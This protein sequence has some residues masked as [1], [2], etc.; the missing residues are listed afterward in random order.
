MSHMP[1]PSGCPIRVVAAHESSASKAAL[2]PRWARGLFFGLMLALVF[3][4]VPAPASANEP[5]CQPL[6]GAAQ[7]VR[8]GTLEVWWL[9]EPAPLAVSKPFALLLKVCPAQAKLLRVDAAMPEHRHGMNYRPSLNDLGDGRWQAEGLLWHMPGRWE[10]RID[11]QLDGQTEVLRQ[12][13]TL[14]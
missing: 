12:S 7:V 6:P 1:M 5:A 9:P 3:V 14:R 4:W 10:L 2:T 11:V 8:A 13:V